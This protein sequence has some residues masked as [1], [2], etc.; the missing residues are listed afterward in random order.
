MIVPGHCPFRAPC[1]LSL[2]GLPRVITGRLHHSKPPDLGQRPAHRCPVCVGLAAS[3]VQEPGSLVCPLA[4]QGAKVGHL[5]ALVACRQCCPVMAAEGWASR[6][7]KGPP[8]PRRPYG[9]FANPAY[10]SL[11]L[12]LCSCLPVQPLKQGFSPRSE[13]GSQGQLAISGSIFGYQA[14]GDATG[15]AAPDFPTA[16]APG[17]SLPFEG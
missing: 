8:R 12:P 10:D 16:M 14:P 2:E 5:C 17:K 3:C 11:S 9:L 1:A 15:R 4:S 6:V 7:P 13:L